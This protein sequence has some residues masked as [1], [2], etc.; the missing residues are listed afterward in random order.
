MGGRSERPWRGR[1]G[2][3]AACRRAR[4]GRQASAARAGPPRRERRVEDDEPS[5]AFP[6]SDV[7]R[8]REEAARTRLRNALQRSAEAHERAAHSGGATGAE[9]HRKA[10]THRSDAVVDRRRADALN[11]SNAPDEWS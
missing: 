3:R 7:S 2:S 4:R 11:T 10:E 1:G 9:H 6:A 5:R 8:Q